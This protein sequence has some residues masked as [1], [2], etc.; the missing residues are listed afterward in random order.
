MKQVELKPGEVSI[1]DKIYRT[2]NMRVGIFCSDEKYKG[3]SI[4]TKILKDQCT[5]DLVV[6]KCKIKN[7]HGRVIS[8][9]TAEEN[10]ALGPINRTSALENAET[11]CVGRALS[12][13]GLGGSEIASSNEVENA[14][15]SSNASD[16]LAH[17]LAVRENFDTVSSIKEHIANDEY[18]EAA[19]VM[20]DIPDEEAM[21]LNLAPTKGGIWTI[22]EKS[23]MR[24]DGAIGKLMSNIKK[25]QTTAEVA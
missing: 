18:K 12:F 19:M 24:P 21:K 9:G 2:V 15:A 23:L 5:D 4:T 14:I 1:R 7:E 6:M 17:C 20:L 25:A 22:K 11:S 13:I 8:T 16:A 3:W 10:R